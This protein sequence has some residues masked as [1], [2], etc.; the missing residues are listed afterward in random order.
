[1]RKL[2]IEQTWRNI[3]YKKKNTFII[4]FNNYSKA[5]AILSQRIVIA[6]I[7]LS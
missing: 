6:A 4:H 2:L 5:Q 3:C 1:M 7:V